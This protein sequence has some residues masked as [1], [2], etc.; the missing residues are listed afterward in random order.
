MINEQF[1]ITINGKKFVS[2]E[3]LLHTAHELGLKGIEVHMLQNPTPEN[4][5]T[6]ICRA[7]V[8]GIDGQTYIDYGDANPSN[9]NSRI[10]PH[11]IRM[12][13]TR[14]KARALRD[15]TNVG[16]TA[17][18]ELGD[19]KTLEPPTL[20]QLNLLKKLSKQMNI[21]INFDELTKDSADTLIE[22]IYKNQMK[23]KQE[24]K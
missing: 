21:K 3:G 6:C 18:E 19:T 1:L 15:F 14:A 22:S 8:I 17:I 11:I 16:M 7:T 23:K 13:A 10:S 2:Y 4:D 20:F 5:Q 24:V 9:V 12:A